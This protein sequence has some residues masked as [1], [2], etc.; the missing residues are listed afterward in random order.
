MLVARITSPVQNKKGFMTTGASILDKFVP[1]VYFEFWGNDKV[2][3]QQL[4]DFRR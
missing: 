4:I 2:L 3:T 1:F